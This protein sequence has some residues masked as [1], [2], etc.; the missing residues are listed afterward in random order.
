MGA[1]TW[2][3]RAVV[4]LT[5]LMGL[6]NVLSAMTPSLRDRVA[7][8][9]PVLPLE[10]RYGSHLA[11]TLTGFA[12]LLLARH[13]WRRKRAA[14]LLTIAI[15]LVSA[16]SHLLKGLDYEEAGL[17]L[18]LA[19][20]LW[21]QRGQ[22]HARSDRP[23]VR[24]AAWVLLAALGFTLAYGIGG[25]A[26]L[27]RHFSVDFYPDQAAREVVLMFVQ[28]DDAGPIPVTRF[29]RYFAD[30]I[31]L[32]AAATMGYALLAL[33]RPVLIRESASKAERA[34]A[35]AIVEAH[36]RTSLAWFAL[37]DDKSYYFSPGGSLVAFAVSR[38]V[39][40]ALGD[41]IG[42]DGDRPAALAGFCEFC[43]S[44]D[45]RPAFLAVE[46]D[47]LAEYQGAGFD[48]LCVGH[49]AIV[50]V[51]DFSLAGG[52]NKDIRGRV[53][54]LTKLG[55]AAHLHE[56]PLSDALLEELRAVSDEWLS[57][58]QGGEK[59]FSVGAFEADYIRRSPV[60]AVHGPNGAICAFANLY[61]EFQRN[62]CTIDLMRRCGDV[63][64]GT[65]E[66]LLVALFEYAKAQ[67]Y[68]TFNLGLSPL[69]GVGQQSGDPARERALRYIFDHSQAFYNFK[70]LYKFKSK[71]HP[72]WSPRFLVYPG[73]STLF[74]V[75]M[76]VISVNAGKG[77]FW[78]CVRER[79]AAAWPKLPV[80][81]PTAPPL[82]EP[83]P[84]AP[85]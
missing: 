12:L 17:A 70:G 2:S 44:N 50:P 79:G 10:V 49:E 69:A 72:E 8:L 37:A 7:L 48:A 5:A 26:L 67:G 28:F 33:L 24:H 21:H 22:F 66:F 35:K 15:L 62:E 42:P 30:S 54:R 1:K 29:G 74:T 18:G 34:R 36:G 85:G 27:D 53:A 56:A 11:A 31:Y 58:V 4:L 6:V 14:C 38:R 73:P 80:R 68:D 40:L 20:W 60:M 9:R 16:L 32:V 13:L 47:T 25:L 75:V 52:R 19:G 43:A 76:A 71:F 59:C 81:E 51:S 46:P 63:E 83:H 77:F 57:L 23:S 64:N 65:M 82:P 3:V 78:R 84:A 61:S 55:Y 39:C 41:I 45:W